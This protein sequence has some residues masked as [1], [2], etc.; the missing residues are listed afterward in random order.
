MMSKVEYEIKLKK[1]E[2]KYYKAL[3]EEDF[4]GAGLIFTSINALKNARIKELEEENKSLD[5]EIREK[6]QRLQEL[7]R[8]NRRIERRYGREF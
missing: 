5:K 8:E 3:E 4:L 7:T 2:E 1:L 6:Q